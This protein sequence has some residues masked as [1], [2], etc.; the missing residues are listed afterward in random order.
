MLEV[1]RQGSI[2]FGTSVVR[3]EVVDSGPFRRTVW[4]QGMVWLPTSREWHLEVQQRERLVVFFPPTDF[5][6]RR[7][8]L[9]YIVAYRGVGGSIG[10]IKALEQS[11]PDS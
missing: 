5:S 3:L 4:I 2:D 9:A 10:M 6:K 7:A 8:C 1:P 11:A